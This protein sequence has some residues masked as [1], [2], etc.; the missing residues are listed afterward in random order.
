MVDF[1]PS[2]PRTERAWKT[3]TLGHNTHL[4][5]SPCPPPFPRTEVQAWAL[6]GKGLPSRLSS[7]T[8]WWD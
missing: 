1:V 6:E 4:S 8:G 3:R 5:L 7:V 2:H